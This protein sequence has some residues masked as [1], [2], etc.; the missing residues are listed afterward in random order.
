MVPTELIVDPPK[1][2]NSSLRERQQPSPLTRESDFPSRIPASKKLTSTSL[3][4]IAL[5]DESS[6]DLGK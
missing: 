4:L 1:R 5:E 3:P 6:C 2:Q